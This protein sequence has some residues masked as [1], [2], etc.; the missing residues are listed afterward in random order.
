VRVLFKRLTD[1]EIQRR[2]AEAAKARE[3]AAKKAKE[4]GAAAGANRPAAA[5]A[6]AWSGLGVPTRR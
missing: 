3:E 6:G 2:E 1:P 5:K 4:G